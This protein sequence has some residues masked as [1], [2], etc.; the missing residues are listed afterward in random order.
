MISLLDPSSTKADCSTFIQEIDK[1]AFPVNHFSPEMEES[2]E[3]NKNE[4]F[5]HLS[6]ENQL[7]EIP[8]LKE[9]AFTTYK[10]FETQQINKTFPTLL[11]LNEK[12]KVAVFDLLNEPFIIAP[13][14]GTNKPEKTITI[15]EIL[16]KIT[17][18]FKIKFPNNEITIEENSIIG[19]IVNSLLKSSYW[20]RVFKNSKI[21]QELLDRLFPQTDNSKQSLLEQHSDCDLLVQIQM[22][23]KEDLKTSLI[24]LRK[25]KNA[26]IEIIQ[27]IVG[28]DQSFQSIKDSYFETLGIVNEEENRFL[29][30]K[31]RDPQ[32]HLIE[33]KFTLKL[34]V[35]QLFP[36][37]AYAITLEFLGQDCIDV[38]PVCRSKG[39][40]DL[41]SLL[42]FHQTNQIWVKDPSLIDKKGF[43]RLISRLSIGTECRQTN[44]L[45]TLYLNFKKEAPSFRETIALFKKCLKDHHLNDSF[46][47]L[48]FYLN[49]CMD[50]IGHLQAQ[51]KIQLWK[52]AQKDKN[53]CFSD[54]THFLSQIQIFLNQHPE[55]IAEVLFFLSFCAA[56]HYGQK[57]GRWDSSHSLAVLMRQIE[58]KK[59]FK[60]ILKG[61][62]Q[63][64]YSV[65]IPYEEV[66]HTKK[67]QHI[68][69]K[70][71]KL[72]SFYSFF[73][74]PLQSAKVEKSELF[75]GNKLEELLEFYES[76]TDL[77][78]PY[79]CH[80]GF[81]FLLIIQAN[82]PK[83]DL[84]KYYLKALPTA[85]FF[86]N[87]FEQQQLF[88]S[89]IENALLRHD[90]EKGKLFPTLL[91]S[92]KNK[93]T[94]PSDVTLAL[95]HDLINSEN[96]NVAK[97][98][99]KQAENGLKAVSINQENCELAYQL[100]QGLMCIN[101]NQALQF[102]ICFQ[103]L[104]LF[105]HSPHLALTILA[106]LCHYYR[107]RDFNQLNLA[108]LLEIQE[109]KSL[110]TNLIKETSIKSTEI[111]PLPKVSRAVSWLVQEVSAQD[112]HE[113]YVLFIQLTHRQ[114]LMTN[115]AEYELTVI[116][117]IEHFLHSHQTSDQELAKK[118]WKELLK[119]TFIFY[120]ERQNDLICT[121]IEEN[122]SASYNELELEKLI[123]KFSQ[124][125]LSSQAKE[126]GISSFVFY[127]RELI[128]AK[129]FSLAAEHLKQLSKWINMTTYE[130]IYLIIVKGYLKEEANLQQKSEWLNSLIQQLYQPELTP[131]LLKLIKCA[132]ETLLGQEKIYPIKQIGY[133]GKLLKESEE[134]YKLFS[135]ASDLK[136]YLWSLVCKRLLAILKQNKKNENRSQIY[137][138]IIEA[139]IAYFLPPSDLLCLLKHEEVKESL[140]ILKELLTLPEDPLKLVK[141]ETV[142]EKYILLVQQLPHLIKEL[143]KVG[144]KH[145]LNLEIEN[146]LFQLKLKNW[147]CESLPLNALIFE[148]IENYLQS[149]S[150]NSEQAYLLLNKAQEAGWLKDQDLKDHIKIVQQLVQHLTTTQQLDNMQALIQLLLKFNSLPDY[151]HIIE[152]LVWN[153]IHISY[154]KPSKTE[155]E[156]TLT[157]LK[158]CYEK[159]II[160]KED[161][162]EKGN[163]IIGILKQQSEL[164]KAIY[165]L[166]QI[167]LLLCKE[168][169]LK[170]W[171]PALTALMANLLHTPTDQKEKERFGE[172]YEF[173]QKHR[174]FFVK[175]SDC[176]WLFLIENL[177][178]QKL[179]QQAW[180]LFDQLCQQGLNENKNKVK[181]LQV[182]L[183]HSRPIA[184]L[185]T[186]IKDS[187]AL[188]IA[189]VKDI[190]PSQKI[191][192]FKIMIMTLLE[193]IKNGKIKSSTKE[194]LKHI[195][196]K[197]RELTP[198]F[199]S[200]STY[201]DQRKELDT[202]F[203]ETLL[204][205]KGH[206]ELAKAIRYLQDL[207]IETKRTREIDENLKKLLTLTIN[208]IAHLENIPV[209]LSRLTL[210]LI[211]TG[212]ELEVLMPIHY[213]K[214]LNILSKTLSANVKWVEDHPYLI[215]IHYHLKD[216]KKFE[217]FCLKCFT[218]SETICE[219][220]S[221][222]PAIKKTLETATAQAVFSKYTG[223][224]Y[225]QVNL[226]ILTWQA[227]NRDPIEAEEVLDF[228]IAHID[229]INSF[230][231][232]KN[233]SQKEVL[234][235][236]LLKN[237]M[238]LINADNES[239]SRNLN[240]WHKC[241]I[242]FFSALSTIY[243]ETMYTDYF[244]HVFL[245]QLAEILDLSYIHSL[246]PD[247]LLGLVQLSHVYSNQLLNNSSDYLD[248]C[249]NYYFKITLIEGSKN[250]QHIF[251]QFMFKANEKGCVCASMKYTHRIL[252][253]IIYKNSQMK[254]KDHIVSLYLDEQTEKEVLKKLISN[255]FNSWHPKLIACGAR[256][257]KLSYD[258]DFSSPQDKVD[259]IWFMNSL[260]I[261]FFKTA[262]DYRKL[263][264]EDLVAIFS[265]KNLLTVF[266]YPY[267]SDF[268]YLIIKNYMCSF[269][270]ICTH[271]NEI[272]E[273][274]DFKACL[275][276]FYKAFDIFIKNDID[277]ELEYNCI[278]LS[279]IMS[280]FS[281][282]PIDQGLRFQFMSQI[283]QWILFILSV[284]EEKEFANRESCLKVV[285][286]WDEI[287]T[288]ILE[289]EKNIYMYKEYLKFQQTCMTLYKFLPFLFNKIEFTP[290]SGND[291][292]LG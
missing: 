156:A 184:K 157:K 161:I 202:L 252:S 131:Y 59:H 251:D 231:T 2:L 168:F 56:I 79:S 18:T 271:Y 111:S 97:L 77:Q 7:F 181:A 169:I 214:A 263:I 113:G 188:L 273:I 73:S 68:F 197:R 19:G 237:L 192:I 225:V 72:L 245:T 242:K 60:I 258:T 244:I 69:H 288:K 196:V 110:T 53:L 26:V 46:A 233:N 227:Y 98:A 147:N 115:T 162:C 217:Q 22:E 178:R 95:M 89:H 6:S 5:D 292:H 42:Y 67:P 243:P 107:Y 208:T 94:N 70:Y 1:T 130:D 201:F 190:E 259:L 183:E 54:L 119:E 20:K 117:L 260:L 247:N 206:W 198:L 170:E 173:I 236:L 229:K 124:L 138:S 140:I 152:D 281:K 75:Q 14:A 287:M 269:E 34:K 49:A 172:A 100:I 81:E 127:L 267:L 262:G 268:N 278:F 159:K 12:E 284:D 289:T 58:N 24:K 106:S 29:I 218:L 144:Y 136:F 66:L 129:K 64:Y 166:K 175:Q 92:L 253:D 21:P 109:L 265:D 132:T 128:I 291:T 120:P 274:E 276:E 84:S 248:Q 185:Q 255:I 280:L 83:E 91:N 45:K 182:I 105:N 104:G 37:D 139:I 9:E 143:I 266:S 17:S 40:S 174:E 55:A 123:Q 57:K 82:F 213:A 290:C 264:L 279:D 194:T 191:A 216:L 235:A 142:K 209:K 133:I 224:L 27:E 13:K 282:F 283:H 38:H 122:E 239:V 74:T 85:I 220:T 193:H 270:I 211:H 71:P 176:E 135:Q 272:A 189:I 246:S 114:W 4:D 101:L 15:L 52:I 134:K 257:I 47:H 153:S 31:I 204:E 158:Q 50:E 145:S 148:I 160:S 187:H 88:L 32:G 90:K 86:Y 223:L 3:V 163:K 102:F 44:L 151:Q 48:A 125:E 228:F 171:Q 112:P 65:W 23:D 230:Y 103:Q 221:I 222:S 96:L 199:S 155:L 61:Q 249:L 286:K 36:Q 41:A 207:L 126:K 39:E 154:K 177:V 121:L 116:N 137:Y 149:R 146:L 108:P 241:C 203:I 232:G 30:V 186:Y 285:N 76:L 164:E 150:L 210:E 87:D 80:L 250:S 167:Q 35:P 25:T 226:K 28:Q 238:V 43:P 212:H 195:L 10:V 99:S 205:E 62:L 165:F 78:D 8:F 234:I 51:E 254:I 240:T 11:P 180:N 93:T 141:E 179:Y 200:A 261:K 277:N 256:L 16:T 63:P 219:L 215:D 33:I 118:L 275:N